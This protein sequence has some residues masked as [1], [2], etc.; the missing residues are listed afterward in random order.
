MDRLDQGRLVGCGR[1][2]P[3]ATPDDI[4]ASPRVVAQMGPEPFVDA[5]GAEPDFDVIVGGRAY[6]P[7]PYAAW[8]T[9]QLRLRRQKENKKDD[10]EIDPRVLG[11]FLHMGKIMEC[12]GLCAVPKSPGATAT[13]YPD[14]V[15]DVRPVAPGSRC[16]P[17][18]V[19]AHSLY[20]NTRPDV[21]RGPGGELRLGA[22]EYRQL[23]PRPAA[24]NCDDDGE[25]AKTVRVS[26]A[27]F[28]RPDAG[29]G[30]GR[31]GYTIKLEAA[32]VVGY[33][34]MTMGSVKDRKLPFN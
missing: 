33:R 2:V 30:G 1:C 23:P 8:C 14:G 28:V 27:V 16:T 13:V 24:D 3:H 5:M 20:E 22:A 26:G 21:L 29:S 19:A 17:T 12:G 15:F 9:H 6:D 4:D 34:A 11:G 32:R 25:L 10:D 18:S 7:A 31:P